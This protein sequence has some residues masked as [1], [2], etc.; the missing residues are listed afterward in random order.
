M[1]NMFFNIKKNHIE[2]LNSNMSILYFDNFRVEG[3]SVE[4][5]NKINGEIPSK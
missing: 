4:E 3:L 1:E 2:Y 5:L